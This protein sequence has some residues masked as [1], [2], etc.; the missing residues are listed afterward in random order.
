MKR[1]QHI[2]WNG[3]VAMSAVLCIATG[4]AWVRTAANREVVG[5]SHHSQ[6]GSDWWSLVAAADSGWLT[7]MHISTRN[8][9]KGLYRDGE[10]FHYRRMKPALVAPSA[11]VWYRWG[12][13]L[14]RANPPRPSK[15]NALAQSISAATV[16]IWLLVGA[17]ALPSLLWLWRT[18]RSATPAQGLCQSCG[19][20]LRATPGRCPEC[21]QRSPANAGAAAVKF[22][23]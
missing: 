16:P 7:L 17:T 13:N 23:S 19:Y 22:S 10:Y 5:F 21:G 15:P 18:M 4:V 2:A 20:D 12:F 14:V 9:S 6:T 11:S 3:F 1:S 8:D